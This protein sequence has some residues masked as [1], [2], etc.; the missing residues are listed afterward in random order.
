MPELKFTVDSAL[1]AELGERLIGRPFIALAELVKNSYDADATHVLIDF[2]VERDRI[3]VSDNG[4]GMTFEDFANFWMLVGSVHKR[5]HPTSRNLHRM[6]T[7]SKGVGRLAVQFL[8]KDFRLETTSDRDRNKKLVAEVKWEQAVAAGRLTEAKVEYDILPSASGF[9]HGTT[10]ALSRLKQKWTQ[11]DIRELAGEIWQL[12]PPSFGLRQTETNQ[13][14]V[15][16]IELQSREERIVSAFEDRLAAIET[17][18]T[19]RL[20]G[21]NDQ[22]DVYVSL[23]FA[24]DDPIIQKYPLSN[25]VLK[26]GAFDIRIY[27][28]INRQPH[29][30]RVGDARDY[31]RKFGGVRVYD[32]G[33]QLSH[34]GKPENDWLGIE[35]DHSHRLA[36]SKLLPAQLQVKRGLSFLP[37]MT[38]IL[39]M[40]SVNTS[41]E[42]QLIITITRDRLQE[43]Q[44]FDNL[45]RMVRWALDFYAMEEAKRQLQKLEKE[46]DRVS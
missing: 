6:M 44:A 46:R 11:K 35:V 32:S 20:T 16:E 40:V 8:S 24:G 36:K 1:L 18:W 31:L 28:L 34:Y 25:C 15:F 30:I 41:T 42:K 33:F 22:G 39:G 37:T 26:D 13:A 7:G 45:R 23:Q 29:G 21:K 38:R 17:I 19:A 2:D 3:I 12:R 9:E 14:E 43:N 27:N 5:E 4:H 10:V